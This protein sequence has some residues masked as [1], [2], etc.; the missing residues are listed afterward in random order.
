[1]R[2]DSLVARG[3]DHGLGIFRP[4]RG[5]FPVVHYA[6]D[7]IEILTVDRVVDRAIVDLDLIQRDDTS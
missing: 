4:Y 7:S 3:V 1:M 2:G 5:G 6:W